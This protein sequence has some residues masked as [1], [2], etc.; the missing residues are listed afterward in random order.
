MTKC[1]CY[2][3][4]RT[5]HKK[6]MHSMNAIAS[7]DDFFSFRVS[8]SFVRSCYIDVIRHRCMCRRTG[9]HEYME[10]RALTL[11]ADTLRVQLKVE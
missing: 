10:R 4:P 9:T 5:N 8:S 1:E 7:G 6:V 3:V 11:Y 2:T